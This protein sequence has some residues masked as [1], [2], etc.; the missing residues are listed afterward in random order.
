LRVDHANLSLLGMRESNQDRVGIEVA[1][2]GALLIAC[3]GMGGHAEGERAAQIAHEVIG[4]RF[5]A[6]SPPLLDPLGFLHLALGAA[7]QQI[8][9]I[10]VDMPLDNRPRATI[11]L[12]LVQRQS[13]YFAHVGD[14]RTYLLR[15]GKVV[16]RTRDHSHVEVLVREGVIL[17]DQAQH[18]PMRNYVESCLG[19][20]PLLPEMDLSTRQALLA[21]DVLLVCTDG[22]WAH[23]DD[24]IIAGAFAAGETPLLE[25]L[26]ALGA[27][28]VAGG[29]PSADN[30][31]AV[32]LR[33]LE[34]T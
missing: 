9:R 12:C 34:S 16:A 8:V 31:S 11:A 15:H 14:S 24:A 22:L 33:F 21:G 10:G 17:A 6:A 20:E 29:G 28:A 7:H 4:A 32:A 27:R 30:T 18:H 2:G 13:A 26:Q 1:E 3:D 25:A 19:G 23:L 5:R